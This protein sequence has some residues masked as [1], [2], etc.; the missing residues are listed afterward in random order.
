MLILSLCALADEVVYGDALGANWQSWSWS[1]TYDFGATDLPHTGVT[2]VDAHIE[3]Y[4]ALSL[5]RSV[6]FTDAALR[7]WVE[8]DAGDL[9]LLL[10]ADGEGYTADP[11]PLTTWATSTSGA[12]TEYVVDLAPFGSHEW[13][14]IDL[15]DDGAT[16]VDVHVDDI[17]LLSLVPDREGTTIDRFTAGLH[18]LLKLT[19]DAFPQVKLVMCEPSV[20]WL[21]EPA[22]ANDLLAPYTQAIHN[23]ARDF[24]AECVVPLHG[25]FEDARKKR[26][27]VQWTTDG[28]HPTSIGHMLIARTWLNATGTL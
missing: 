5:H 6:G 25:A 27:A 26:E 22:N 10:E 15:F 2:S 11:V 9:A 28:V 18:D 23:L 17:E 8:G 21:Q 20:L 12:W 19:R 4:G 13:T 16:A 14:R 3:P 24:N 7:F 1:G